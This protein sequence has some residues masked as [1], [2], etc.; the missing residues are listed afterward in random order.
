MKEV[1][2]SLTK[3]GMK[4]NILILSISSFIKE[5]K[6]DLSQRGIDTGTYDWAGGFIFDIIGYEESF[7]KLYI[8]F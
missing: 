2:D 4:A 3:I 1:N 6:S 8:I 7:G 5:D